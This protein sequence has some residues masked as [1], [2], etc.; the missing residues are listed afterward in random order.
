MVTSKINWFVVTGLAFL[1]GF[2][3]GGSS[4]YLWKQQRAEPPR[5]NEFTVTGEVF[6]QLRTGKTKHAPGAKVYVFPLLS[7]A[8]REWTDLMDKLAHSDAWKQEGKKEQL[9]D[10]L[11]QVVPLLP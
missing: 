5:I 3:S 10:S 11:Q 1:V 2:A 7:L 4:V 8:A 9:V 6:L